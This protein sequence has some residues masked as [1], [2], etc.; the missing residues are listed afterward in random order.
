MQGVK[1]V[2]DIFLYS[3]PI[4]SGNE[5]KITFEHILLF[6]QQCNLPTCDSFRSDGSH[7]RTLRT[8]KRE[9]FQINKQE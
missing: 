2:K 8:D 4:I 5:Q 1:N 3:F 7:M 6:S 9:C